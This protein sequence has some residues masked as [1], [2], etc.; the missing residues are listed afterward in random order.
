ME[1]EVTTASDRS[2]ARSMCARTSSGMMRLLSIS[3]LLVAEAIFIKELV[4]MSLDTLLDWDWNAGAHLG[5]FEIFAHDM[6]F[7]VLTPTAAPAAMLLSLATTRNMS[8]ATIYGSWPRSALSLPC[9]TKEKPF[10][11][12]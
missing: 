9:I 8:K 10:L 6:T 5:T 7:C 3:E 1:V 2:V 11:R 12:I 4:L